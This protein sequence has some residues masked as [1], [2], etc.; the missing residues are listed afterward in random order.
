MISR[1]RSQVIDI[2]VSDIMH[3]GNSIDSSSRNAE[4]SKARQTKRHEVEFEGFR[5]SVTIQYSR[6]NYHIFIKSVRGK[7]VYRHISVARSGGNFVLAEYSESRQ[8]Q[9]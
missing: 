2:R 8:L 3:C 9:T 5:H 7:V 6:V 4:N 1:S